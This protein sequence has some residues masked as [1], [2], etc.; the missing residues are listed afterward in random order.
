MQWALHE[1]QETA[2]LKEI[3]IDKKTINLNGDS[4]DLRPIINNSFA[5]FKSDSNT[6]VNK[7]N[8]GINLKKLISKL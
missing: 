6:Q 5:E 3:N 1:Q 7:I 2:T 8:I 4:F